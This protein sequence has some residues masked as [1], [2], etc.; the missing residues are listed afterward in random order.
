MDDSR[1]PLRA[2]RRYCR[3]CVGGAAQDVRRCTGPLTKGEKDRCHLWPY[4]LGR[5]RKS[6]VKAPDTPLQ[7]IKKNCTWCSGGSA[8]ERNLCSSSMC[9]L[10]PFRNGRLPTT[11][12]QQCGMTGHFSA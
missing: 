3:D 5:G 1:S 2:I 12:R 7:A 8:R 4:R 10:K 9:A 6:G 11:E